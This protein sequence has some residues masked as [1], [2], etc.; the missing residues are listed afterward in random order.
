M[1]EKWSRGHEFVRDLALLTLDRI[2]GFLY[3][4]F[5][6]SLGAQ[7][8]SQ[9]VLLLDAERLARLDAVRRAHFSAGS[10]PDTVLADDETGAEQSIAAAKCERDAQQRALPQIVILSLAFFDVER[11]ADVARIAGVERIHRRVELE[12][13]VYQAALL[14]GV[15]GMRH[16]SAQAAHAQ[17]GGLSY[18]RRGSGAHEVVME[19]LSAWSQEEHPSRLHR[20]HVDD[21]HARHPVGIDGR[22][23]AVADRA[24]EAQASKRI[25]LLGRGG[26]GLG[27]QVHALAEAHLGSCRCYGVHALLLLFCGFYSALKK[28]PVVMSR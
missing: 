25:D 23:R 15:V 17:V 28:K 22:E 7:P 4:P 1:R 2:D 21:A 8:A 14:V 10:A 19:R 24:E 5:W 16:A 6:A 13:H 11:V 12:H 26:D 3:R 18:E 9:A 27:R 20:H